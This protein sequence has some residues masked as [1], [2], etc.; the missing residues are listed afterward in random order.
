MKLGDNLLKNFQGS[1]NIFNI[2]TQPIAKAT[3]NFIL[4]EKNYI[5]LAE[6]FGE[7]LK[8]LKITFDSIVCLRNFDDNKE[9]MFEQTAK[10]TQ[11]IMYHTL[12][13]NQQNNL[14]TKKIF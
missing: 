5:Q 13:G 2:D 1:W 10:L 3:H 9:K 7:K 6:E 8:K 12:L 4:E 11:G 14:N